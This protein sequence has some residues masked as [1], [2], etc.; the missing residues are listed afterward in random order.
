MP[1]FVNA[2]NLLNVRQT[3]YDPLLRPVRA[4]NGRWTVD[5]RAPGE[6]FPVN[7]GIRLSFGRR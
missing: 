3:K 5:A 7:G 1:L 2:E 6:G 4:P